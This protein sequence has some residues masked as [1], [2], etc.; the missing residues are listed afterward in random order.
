MPVFPDQVRQEYRERNQSAEHRPARPDQPPLRG[1]HQRRDH[2]GAEEGGRVLGLKAQ[3]GEEPE[4]QPHPGILAPDHAHEHQR[5]Q[6]PEERL[7]SIGR[8]FSLA[9]Q[10]VWRAQ[11]R[12]RRHPLGEFP[13]A[14]F[15]DDESRHQHEGNTG[16]DGGRAN[17]VRR[18]RLDN[19]ETPQGTRSKLRK[20]KCYTFRFQNRMPPRRGFPYD[21]DFQYCPP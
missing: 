10:V 15:A 2:R 9:A 8:Q 12:D 13:A 20:L 3:T 7:D 17:Y 4:P 1:Q 18:Y 5:T 21:R 6:R 14:Q 16:D 11:D 19:P